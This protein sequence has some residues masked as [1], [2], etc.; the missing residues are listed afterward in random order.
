MLP[1]Y[2]NDFKPEIPLSHFQKEAVNNLLKAI[3]AGKLKL[4]DNNCLC[5]NKFPERD[6]V[7]AEK[8][9]YGIPVKNIICSR[10]GLVRS[11][12]VFDEKSNLE[13]Y[14]NY[15]RAIY[16]GS[17]I[18][19]EDF[20]NDQ[21]NRGKAFFSLVRKNIKADDIK[22]VLEI[23]C[24]SG[25]ILFPFYEEGIDCLGV[26]FDENYLQFGREKGLDL[27][28]GDYKRK[29]CDE[30]VDLL[31]LS[32]VMEHFTDPIKEMTEV[33]KKVK[34]NKYLLVE[35][36]GLFN[37]NKVY[38]KPIKYF[39]NAHVFNYFY[40]HLKIFFEK[41]GLEIIYGDEKCVF[42]LKKS[43]TWKASNIGCIYEDSLAIYPK[44]VERMILKAYFQHRF[45][46]NPYA[47]KNKI[48]KTVNLLGIT[49]KRRK[50]SVQ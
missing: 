18:G 13:F 25:G 45:C 38:F 23:G 17:S 39:Q 37:L 50:E 47:W 16:G 1:I 3:E 29:V 43:V 5:D 42:L 2:K 7:I 8:D 22:K 32:H 27:I 46:L 26:D 33:I 35:V 34:M 11:K 41:L 28:C 40:D 21:K 36:P 44:K 20:F 49:H 48:R 31:I 30:S 10:C 4:V 14:K 24:G 19:N 12:K 9:R 6:I 15:Y